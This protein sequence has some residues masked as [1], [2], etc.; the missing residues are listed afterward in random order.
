MSQYKTKHLDESASRAARRV[1]KKHLKKLPVRLKHAAKANDRDGEKVHKLRVN[2]RKAAVALEL[3]DGFLPGK[4]SRRLEKRI[5]KILHA[6]GESRD[7]G[8][9]TKKHAGRL[10]AILLKKKGKARKALEK[11]AGF[12][13]QKHLNEMIADVL[14]KAG[15][16]ARLPF[17]LWAR[18]EIRKLA[19]KFF[20]AKPASGAS[21]KK[22]HKFRIHG[23][24]LRYAIEI[25]DDAFDAAQSA[26][27]L[28]RMESFQEK[29]GKINDLFSENE[30][31]TRWMQD[32]DFSGISSL[33]RESIS[34]NK[35]ELAR[36]KA[37]FEKWCSADL[38]RKFQSELEN[39][40]KA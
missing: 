10:A 17:R 7:L 25:S 31:F 4:K 35:H 13:H 39:M 37:A 36:R 30:Y 2:C 12:T 1:V 5:A 11:Q 27:V 14:E 18:P 15:G 40:L 9:M 23:K 24:E 8:V 21:R 38:M 3:F 28:K 16:H 6:T 22:L 32:P 33:L 29:L 19:G 20:A 34:S 26:R